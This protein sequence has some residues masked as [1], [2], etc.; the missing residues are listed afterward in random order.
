MSYVQP[1]L[2][3]MTAL[4]IGPSNIALPILFLEK[5]LKL[6]FS[7][8]SFMALSLKKLHSSK[9]RVENIFLVALLGFSLYLTFTDFSFFRKLA[10]YL[11]KN[12]TIR[13]LISCQVGR[14]FL[15]FGLTW[16]IRGFSFLPVTS[17]FYLMA[18]YLLGIYALAFTAT[19][20][21][22]PRIQ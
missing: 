19:S 15:L 12:S 5:V 21:V 18:I 16:F 22:F 4:L 8:F 17:I 1:L 2:E 7:T 9:R 13:I 10:I 11:S 3:K 20:N 14:F 6:I